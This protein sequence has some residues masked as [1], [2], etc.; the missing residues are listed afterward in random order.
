MDMSLFTPISDMICQPVLPVVYGQSLSYLEELEHLKDYVNNMITSVNN[1]ITSHNALAGNYQGVL[2]S[3]ST[4]S[5]T[6]TKMQN[7]F[8]IKDGSINISK[9]DSSF[10]ENIKN[11]VTEDFGNAAKFVSFG[12]TDDGYFIA[13]KPE[14]WTDLNFSTDTDGHLLLKF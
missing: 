14:S 6:I 12:L 3:L 2:N 8:Y 7:S 9:M 4:L 5:D 13:Y 10:I 1:T 11:I